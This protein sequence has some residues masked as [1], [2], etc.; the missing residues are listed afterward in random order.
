M[1]LKILCNLYGWQIQKK[2]ASHSTADDVRIKFQG[3]GSQLLRRPRK[4]ETVRYKKRN[5]RACSFLFV[6]PGLGR[7][8]PADLVLAVALALAVV[9]RGGDDG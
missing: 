6:S 1:K 8:E 4:R 5:E 7:E 3:V 2:T 9:T